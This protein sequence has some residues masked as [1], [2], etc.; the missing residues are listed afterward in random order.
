MGDII[1]GDKVCLGVLS[2][3]GLPSCDKSVLPD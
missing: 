1:V 2:T 3:S